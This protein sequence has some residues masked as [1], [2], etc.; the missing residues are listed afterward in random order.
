MLSL[1]LRGSLGVRVCVVGGMCVDDD[2]VVDECTCTICHLIRRIPAYSLDLSV[3][4][5]GLSGHRGTFW[6]AA[7]LVCRW[8]WWTDGSLFFAWFCSTEE[9]DAGGGGGVVVSFVSLFFF[10]LFFFFL[11][12]HAA[13]LFVPLALLC[14]ICDLHYYY[15][16]GY[17]ILLRLSL[18]LYS[19]L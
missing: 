2:D 15:C 5:D 14:W 3:S 17:C 6:M 9:P 4:R 16:S 11:L 8:G 12:L 13:L 10:L 19:T 1:K 18:I 7:M